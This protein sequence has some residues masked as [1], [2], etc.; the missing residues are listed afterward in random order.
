MLPPVP[1]YEKVEQKIEYHRVNPSHC[2]APSHPGTLPHGTVVSPPP[3]IMYCSHWKNMPGKRI[4]LRTTLSIPATL[5]FPVFCLVIASSQPYLSILSPSTPWYN[6]RI[7]AAPI[8]ASGFCS[9]AVMRRS[10]AGRLLPKATV[11]DSVAIGHKADLRRRPRRQASRWADV[12]A[13]SGLQNRY[14]RT[15]G[16]R[17]EV[18]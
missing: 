13:L 11:C 4:T 12:V 8:G 6:Q 5:S 1:N 17:G 7:L 3:T 14:R 10:N 16:D 9:C 2:R 15:P 18:A